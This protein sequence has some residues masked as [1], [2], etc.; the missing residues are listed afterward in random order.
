MADRVIKY[1]GEFDASQ[2]LAS[3]KKV[4]SEMEKGGVDSSVFKGV[5]KDIEKTE[6]LI[7]QMMA[8]IQTGFKD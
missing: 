3:L 5:D 1:K 4:R 7:T 2:I 8:K 6:K